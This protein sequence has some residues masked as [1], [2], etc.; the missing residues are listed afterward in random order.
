M[1]HG[2][3]LGKADHVP[4]RVPHVRPSDKNEVRDSRE[5]RKGHVVASGM[6]RRAK[7]FTQAVR[8]ARGALIGFIAAHQLRAIVQIR[9]LHLL[10]AAIEQCCGDHENAEGYWTQ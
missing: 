9:V 1:Y 5:G 3:F 8:R 6:R 4:P 7:D 10:L 2:G